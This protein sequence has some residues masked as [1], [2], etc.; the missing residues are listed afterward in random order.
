MRRVL[1]EDEL[2]PVLER[3]GFA[4]IVLEDLSVAEQIAAFRAAEIIVSPHG[5]GLTNLIFSRP[6][7][8]ILEVFPQNG[9][10]PSAFMRMATLLSI[11]YGYL[12]AD[13]VATPL[14]EQ[15][16]VNADIICPVAQFEKAVS[17]ILPK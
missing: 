2:Q 8:R 11:D 4:T 6:G 7:I 16:P 13:A 14:S 15:T 3:N 10:H 17:A 1:N 5:A 12:C 9:L